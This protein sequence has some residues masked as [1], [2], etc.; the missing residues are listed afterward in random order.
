MATQDKVRIV[1]IIFAI[2][3]ATG[4]LLYY[5]MSRVTTVAEIPTDGQA[6]L[7]RLRAIPYINFTESISDKAQA[8]V[9]YH[10]HEQAWQGYNLYC[11][12]TGPEAFLLDMEGEVVHKWT[13]TEVPTGLWD[14]TVMLDRGELLIVNTSK[15]LL[16]LGRYSNLLW[17]RG[18]MSVHHDIA[19]DDDGTL[20]VIG[21]EVHE[22]R[23]LNVIFSKIFHLTSDGK[24]LNAYST[25]EN[26]DKIKQAFN[27]KSFLDTRLDEVGHGTILRRLVDKLQSLIGDDK[28]KDIEV[29]EYFHANT[30]TL[31]QDSELGRR[32]SRFKKGNLLTCLRNVNQ[33]A[34]LDRNTWDILWVWGEGVLEEPHHPT[35]TDDGT[36]LIFDN[37]AYRHY[38]KIIEIDPITFETVWEYVSDPPEDFYSPT[39]GSAQRLPNGNTLVC[40]ADNGRSFEVTREGEIVWEWYNPKFDKDRREMIYRMMR[41]APEWVAAALERPELTVQ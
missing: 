24:L 17:G 5:L 10:D 31:L 14:Y 21:K 37:G 30:V 19:V 7:D 38:S 6:R 9:V 25:Y 1:F 32:D 4:G 28:D 8:G 27:Q 2:L 16:K 11:S 12:R 23:G 29:Y 41:L 13:Y 18:G 34:V 15:L 35:L 39:K 3:L 22:Y 26:L 36:I 33:I 40:D 20:F